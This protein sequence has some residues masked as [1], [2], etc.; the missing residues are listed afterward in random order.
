MT[1]EMDWGARE[2]PSCL[3][4]QAG[5]LVQKQPCGFS[6]PVKTINL[7]SFIPVVPTPDPG[8]HSLPSSC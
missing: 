2:A 8:T 4:W 7:K 5:L 6:P 1:E 3:G